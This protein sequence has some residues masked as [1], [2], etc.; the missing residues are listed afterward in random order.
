TLRLRQL[1][2]PLRLL[3][4]GVLIAAREEHLCVLSG[5]LV[6]GGNLPPKRLGR[7]RRG[8]FLGF[9]RGGLCLLEVTHLGGLD[10]L[11]SLRVLVGGLLGSLPGLPLSS[12]GL[13]PSLAQGLGVSVALPLGLVARLGDVLVLVRHVLLPIAGWTPRPHRTDGKKKGARGSS[14]R[15]GASGG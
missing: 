11:E 8:G 6:L 1:R 9:L 10:V 2:E 4:D 13:L 14:R 5:D 12:E 15:G 3:P 7:R